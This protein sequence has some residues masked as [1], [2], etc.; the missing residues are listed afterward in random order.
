MG[1][2][3]YMNWHDLNQLAL[4]IRSLLERIQPGY[5]G[6]PSKIGWPLEHLFFF[7]I[8]TSVVQGCKDDDN[9]ISETLIRKITL[10][11]IYILY[12]IF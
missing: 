10:I 6:T 2:P 4:G 12:F 7:L 3:L 1:N 9:Y 8:Y 5:L 11:Y